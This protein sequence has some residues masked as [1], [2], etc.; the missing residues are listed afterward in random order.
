M[1]GENHPQWRG[2]K[3]MKTCEQCGIG[4]EVKPYERGIRRFCSRKCHDNWRSENTRGENSPCYKP[5]VELICKQCGNEFEVKPAREI[6]SRFCSRKCHDNWRSEN[7]RGENHPDYK[8]KI[9]KMCEQCGKEY[10]VIPAREIT[11]RFCSLECKYKWRAE[12]LRGEDSPL[13]KVKSIKTCIWCGEK[14]E[15]IPS[16]N[17][18]RF[19][20]HKCKSK[21]QA[22]NWH[23][24]D[25][26]AWHG[27]MITKICKQCGIEYKVFQSEKNIRH[28]CSRECKTEWMVGENAPGWKGGISFEPYCHK[29]NEKFKESIREMFGRV[30][31]LCLMTEEENGRKLGVHHVYYNKSCLC[32]DVKCEFVP[33]CVPCHAKTNHDREYWVTLIMENLNGTNKIL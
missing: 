18:S 25:S 24:E 6:T 27:G 32:D 7:I 1:R 19:C 28:F 17:T 3:S 8:P 20:S 2:G 10:E 5:R 14:Y 30:C 4:F 13:W 33:L 21:W 16:N 29:F 9:K 11:S 26:P 31:F 12:N 23:G 15:V 22:E